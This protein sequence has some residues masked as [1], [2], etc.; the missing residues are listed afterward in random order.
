MEEILSDHWMKLFDEIYTKAIQKNLRESNQNQIEF[1]LGLLYNQLRR[2]HGYCYY[3][4]ERTNKMIFEL[5]SIV[6]QLNYV[7]LGNSREI[8]R[9]NKIIQ[10]LAKEKLEH[11]KTQE[12]VRDMVRGELREYFRENGGS[13]KARSDQNSGSYLDPHQNLQADVP[14]LGVDRNT[15]TVSPCLARDNQD[16]AE[17]L[18]NISSSVSELEEVEDYSSQNQVNFESPASKLQNKSP[19]KSQSKKSKA[20]ILSLALQ[21]LKIKMEAQEQDQKQSI[22]VILAQHFKLDEKVDTLQREQESHVSKNLLEATQQYVEEVLDQKIEKGILETIKKLKK[23]RSMPNSGNKVNLGIQAHDSTQ[24]QKK[25][26][27]PFKK[28]AGG[29]KTKTRIEVR[30]NLASEDPSIPQSKKIDNLVDK[31]QEF[32]DLVISLGQ[33]YV[34]DLGEFSK[35][36]TQRN[37]VKLSLEYLNL[38]PEVKVVHQVGKFQK[39]CNTVIEGV[40]EEN[41]LGVQFHRGCVHTFKGRIYK[42]ELIPRWYRDLVFIPDKAYYIYDSLKKELFVQKIESQTKLPTK[43][44]LVPILSVNGNDEWVGRTLRIHPQHSELNQNCNE[45]QE[46]I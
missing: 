23:Q 17:N 15:I 27:N 1:Q 19:S 33:G 6:K 45:G 11:Q 2:L 28:I 43:E 21:Q 35:E 18:R 22:S 30:K 40:D 39:G 42:H 32:Q 25:S 3:E 12:S 4:K 13:F 14:V 44:G 37:L 5:S 16:K 9:L 7:C 36:L 31:V 26:K 8:L 10:I 38:N 20:Q 41:F 34:G 46:K 29:N 24:L